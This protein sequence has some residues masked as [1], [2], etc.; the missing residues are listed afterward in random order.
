MAVVL[1]PMDIVDR[2]LYERTGIYAGKSSVL[3]TVSG[4]TLFNAEITGLTAYNSRV[5][6]TPLDAGFKATCT[7]YS[8]NSTGGTVYTGYNQCNDFY[9]G[10]PT[11]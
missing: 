8:L 9:F 4:E 11:P 10:K 2:R 6:T 3:E 7:G 1:L 5:Q